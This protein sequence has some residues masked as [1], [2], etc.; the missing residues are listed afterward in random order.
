[1]ALEQM[2]LIAQN[3][4]GLITRE[5]LIDCGLTRRG[6]DHRVRKGLLERVRPTVFRI[7][8]ALGSWE[9]D[10]M[11]VCLWAG[12]DSAA[13]HR[14]AAALWRLPH[15][16]TGPIDISSPRQLSAARV[17][18]YRTKSLREGDIC[19]LS[20]IP[21][22][23]IERTLMDLG[24]TAPQRRLED[25]VDDAIRRRLMTLSDL[26]DLIARCRSERRTGSRALRDVL[27][28]TN[29][30]VVATASA[31]E[32]RLLRTLMKAKLPPPVPQYTIRHDGRFIARVDFAY[33]AA[34]LAIEAQS[35]RWHSG[36]AAYSRDIGR[37]NAIEAIGWDLLLVTW[38]E[39]ERNW[40]G[41]TDRVRAAVLP[42]LT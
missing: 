30:R 17:L 27:E 5:Q 6:I 28:K 32:S 1:M 2:H 31:F 8:G 36:P 7:A 35:W 13:S 34:R 10:L 19:E 23:S 20:G 39:I 41:F 29:V 38:H 11:G 25:A 24:A 15:F 26:R 3:Q 22:T 40:K 18:S 4:Y 14:S 37:K 33:P 16:H 42:H 21:A 12:P 9:Q